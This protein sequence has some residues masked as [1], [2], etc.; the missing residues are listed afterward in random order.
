M[1]TATSPARSPRCSASS[2]YP[3]T[4]PDP[5][6]VQ[7]PARFAI[8]TFDT[9]SHRTHYAVVTVYPDASVTV[10]PRLGVHT[11]YDAATSPG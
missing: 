7:H 2:P 3:S 6:N 11:P 9:H 4:E 1:C 10:S 8:L 5:G